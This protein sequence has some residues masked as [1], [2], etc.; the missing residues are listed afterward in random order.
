[1]NITSST[2]RTSPVP[3]E[4]AARVALA[5]AGLGGDPSIAMGITVHGS[6]TEFLSAVHDGNDVAALTAKMR[7]RIRNFA[8]GARTARVLEHT[9]QCGL[10]ILIPEHE[11]WPTQLCDLRGL[12]PLVL[13]VRGDADALSA[14]SVALTGTSA[15]T[16]IGIHTAI[17]LS[18]GLAQRGWVI[19][20]GAG[21][22]IDQIA[23][24][25]ADAM[26]GKSVLVAPASLDRIRS[27]GNRQVQVSELPP[28]MTAT[29]RAQRRSKHLLAA[30]AVKTII[31]EAG[32]TSG[33]LRVAEGARAMRRPVGVVLGPPATAPS[34]GCALFGGRDDV[35]VVESIVDADRLR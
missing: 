23:L 14:P 30:L 22:G 8:T 9:R 1:M 4:V 35:T 24:R 31:V 29:V 11:L 10:G 34:P 21:G 19:A 5:C 25:G 33:A 28:G 7:R 26:N 16:A 18:T 12:A 15:A 3:Q 32:A 27:A 13:W 20:A 2:N 6:A 17:E